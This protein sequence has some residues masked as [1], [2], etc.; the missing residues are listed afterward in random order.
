MFQDIDKKNDFEGIRDFWIK[1]G[2][3]G[4]LGITA[5]EEYGGE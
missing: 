3:Q 2:D 4:L 5:P 1:L